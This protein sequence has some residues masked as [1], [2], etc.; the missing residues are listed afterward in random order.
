MIAAST[1]LRKVVGT[2]NGKRKGST[3]GADNLEEKTVPGGFIAFASSFVPDQLAARA[4]KFL[5]LDEIDRFTRSA[6]TEGDPVALAIKRTKTFEG[7]SRKIVIVSTPTS[8]FGSRINEWFKRG[9]QR[10]W[11]VKCPDCEHSSPLSIDMLHAEES[12]PETAQLAC[13]ACGVLHNDRTRRRMVAAGRWEATATGEKGIRSYHLNELASEFSTLASVAQSR[14]AAKT[15]EQKQAFYNTTLAEVYDAGTEIDLSPS[16]LQ[17][18]ST[19]YG[20][21]YPSV[22]QFVTA[23]IDVQGDRLECTFLGTAGDQAY[24]LNHI[25]LRGD[26]SAD[27]VWNEMDAALG[28]TFMTKDGRQLPIAAIG[29]DTG[30][31]AD[32]VIKFVLMQRRKMRRTFALKGVSGF[33]KPVMREGGRLK[34][35][36]RLHLVGVDNLKLSLAKRLSM[37][38]PGPGYIHLPEHLDAAYFDGLASEQ[39][40]SGANKR[41]FVSSHFEKIIKANEA[42]DALVYS[43]AVAS[44][45]KP[46][47]TKPLP[48]QPSDAER[49]AAVAA[50]LR[51]DQHHGIEAIYPARRA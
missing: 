6:G 36:M 49:L 16:E 18:R 12:K 10:R 23:G 35:Q 4:I 34:G 38:A 7:A 41:G 5:F 46:I 42:L 24:V 50:K 11:F 33:D 51:G 9:D 8:R 48:P 1:T 14:D 3:G 27:A 37:E 29:C 43:T 17:Q 2:G 47:A 22:L 28:A 26:S 45:V 31:A 13:D 32:Q 15:P 44:A 19:N 20:P 39:L 21:P 30:F 25:V 40:V